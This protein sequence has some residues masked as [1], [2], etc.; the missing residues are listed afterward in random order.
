MV[1]SGIG[2]LGCFSPDIRIRV[3]FLLCKMALPHG[4]TTTR[5]YKSG[6]WSAEARLEIIMHEI[7]LISTL[8]L[9]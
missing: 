5:R 1:T 3:V 4:F 2:D 6:N 8:K 7:Y 9:F